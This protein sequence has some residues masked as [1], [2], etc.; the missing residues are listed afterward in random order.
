MDTTKLDIAVELLDSANRM[1]ADARTIRENALNLIKKVMNV[2]EKYVHPLG[3]GRL[4]YCKEGK[5]TDKF[6]LDKFKLLLVTKGKVAATVVKQLVNESTTPGIK[7][8]AAHIR[9][10]PPS[11]GKD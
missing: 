4:D 8:R 3:L 2:G 10:T 1:E 6:D 11:P 7:G 9:Y 5:P